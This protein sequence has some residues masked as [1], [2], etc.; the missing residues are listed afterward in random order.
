MLTVSVSEGLVN[1][2]MILYVWAF[3]N[4]A[5]PARRKS[6]RTPSLVRARQETLTG[7][8]LFFFQAGPTTTLK[9]HSKWTKD[10]IFST[11]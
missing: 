5:M 7:P 6:Q 11:E 3:L 4:L 8:E 9:V 10:E 2:A 1:S